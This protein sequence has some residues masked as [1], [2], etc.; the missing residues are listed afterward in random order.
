MLA[1]ELNSCQW[2]D[3]IVA[4]QAFAQINGNVCLVSLLLCFQ[5]RKPQQGWLGNL[6][7]FAAI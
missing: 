6:L 4:C 7:L 5:N 1:V 2:K 3:R